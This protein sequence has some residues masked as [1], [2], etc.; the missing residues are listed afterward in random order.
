MAIE[1]T[2]DETEF[3][4]GEE[5]LVRIQEEFAIP[6]SIKLE[7]ASPFKRIYIGSV[8]QVVLH[9]YELRARLRLSLPTIIA[10]LLK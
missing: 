10:E 1:D 6:V 7:L 5:D 2:P 9:K 4:L 8:T 3:A